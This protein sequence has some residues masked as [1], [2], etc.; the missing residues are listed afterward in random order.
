[1]P[2]HD[3]KSDGDD[4]GDARRS[5]EELRAIMSGFLR[6]R[7]DWV[8]LLG[9]RNN[10]FATPRFWIT[11]V[12]IGAFFLF[13]RIDFLAAI[14][15]RIEILAFGASFWFGFSYTCRIDAIASVWINDF[16][17]GAIAIFLGLV[18]FAWRGL[19][20]KQSCAIE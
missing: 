10:L 12:S 1:L 20:S 7:S 9:R 19:I 18:V 3:T 6:D 13:G 17:L 4:S 5:N 8:F 2:D 15:F 11:L 16:A 14:R